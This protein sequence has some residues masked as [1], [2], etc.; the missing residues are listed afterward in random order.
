MLNLSTYRVYCVL[1]AVLLFPHGSVRYKRSGPDDENV[2]KS[3]ILVSEP[4]LPPL[5]IHNLFDIFGDNNIMTK[6]I[7]NGKVLNKSQIQVLVSSH[8]STSSFTLPASANS[9]VMYFLF[10]MRLRSI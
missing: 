1:L 3:P 7:S 5:S 4:S 8:M 2:Q 6:A 10:G 9:N